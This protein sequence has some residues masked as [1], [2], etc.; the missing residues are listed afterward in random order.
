MTALTTSIVVVDDHNLFR[1][2]LI[3]LLGSMP[4]FSTC[5]DGAS[6]GEAVMLADKKRPD[7]VLLDIEMPGPGAP[8]TIRK[9]VEVSPHTRVV[10]LTMHDDPDLVRSILDAGAAG[11][12]LKSA[13]RDEL[14][15]AINAAR[16]N[17]S[18]VLVCVSRATLLNLGCNGA[19]HGGNDFLSRRQVEVIR[20][21]ASGG[22][23]RDIAAALLVTEGTVKRHLANIYAKLGARSRIDAVSKATERG[24][25][26]RALSEAAAPIN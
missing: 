19:A 7:V 4:E 5:G 22:S 26:G 2:G 18:T 15:A 12:L 23:N 11:Y 14:V 8:A 21:L 3:E 1:A 16:R 9:I 25:I 20:H 24:I 13:G 10:V 17:N 6:G